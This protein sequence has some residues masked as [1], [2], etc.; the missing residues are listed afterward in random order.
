[1]VSDPVGDFLTRIRNAQDRK[2]EIVTV[3]A[4]NMIVAIA[5][6]LK[7]EGFII[8]YDVSD[9]EVQKEVNLTLKYVNNRP[10]IRSLKRVSKPGIRKY[11]GY[12]DIKQIKNGLGLAIFSTPK[13][14]ITGEDAIK[15][16]VGGEYICEIF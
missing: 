14:V 2:K 6:I 9:S 3:P 15:S 8:S 5:D 7:N 10:A 1:M 13:G 16:K 11:T 4:S 12:K